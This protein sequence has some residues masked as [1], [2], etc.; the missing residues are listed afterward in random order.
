MNNRK[1]K[2]QEQQKTKA[3]FNKHDA[4]QGFNITL[5]K[6]ENPSSGASLYH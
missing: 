2:D 1:N 4:F 5:C 6:S 3:I